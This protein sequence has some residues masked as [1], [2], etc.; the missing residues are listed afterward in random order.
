MTERV[1]DLSLNL[2]LIT[3]ATCFLRDQT[4]NVYFCDAF[5]TRVGDVLANYTNYVARV[6]LLHHAKFKKR[7][8]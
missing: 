3:V 5:G 7:N 2:L 8:S 1:T 6:R 4:K